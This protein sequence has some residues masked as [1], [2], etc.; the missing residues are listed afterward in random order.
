M[1][2]FKNRDTYTWLSFMDIHHNL[3]ISS[4]FS[5]AVDLEIQD[6]NYHM[7]D[8]VK[9]PFRG[10]SAEDTAR[11]ISELKKIDHHLKVL[12]DFIESNYTDEEI[13]ITLVSDHANSF[14]DK[15]NKKHL[16]RKEKLH[17]PFMIRGTHIKEKEIH[18]VVENVDILPTVL[19]FANINYKDQVFDG[20]VPKVFMDNDKEYIFAESRYPN[21]TYKATIKDLNNEVFF[22]TKSYV[23][24]DGKVDLASY[25]FEVFDMKNDKLIQ[26]ETIIKKYKKLLLTEVNVENL[27]L[28]SNMD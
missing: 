13:L 15:S 10:Y 9:T 2:L 27:K 25:T 18:D 21:Q 14:T 17:V 5:S 11:Y 20:C 26:D 23:N 22:E 19:N 24:D 4:G 12:Y 8:R 6:H 16:L 3:N 1:R 7:K 28:T